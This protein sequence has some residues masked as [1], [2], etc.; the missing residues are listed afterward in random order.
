MTNST[1][2][3]AASFVSI[4]ASAISILSY[5]NIQPDPGNLYKHLKKLVDS[6]CCCHGKQT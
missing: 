2:T 1:L 6:I 3:R 4:Y 5:S